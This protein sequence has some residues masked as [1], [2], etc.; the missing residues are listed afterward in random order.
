MPYELLR[1]IGDFVYVSHLTAV[2]IV[3]AASFV[4]LLR[5]LPVLQSIP[6]LRWAAFLCNNVFLALRHYIPVQCYLQSAEG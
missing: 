4:L 6:E 1:I 2:L 3:A 5:T